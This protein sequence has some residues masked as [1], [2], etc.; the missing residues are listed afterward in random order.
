M[1]LSALRNYMKKFQVDD[2]SFAKQE[3]W[4]RKRRIAV[5]HVPQNLPSIFLIVIKV[6]LSR[7]NGDVNETTNRIQKGR[8]KKT[9]VAAYI[10]LIFEFPLILFCVPSGA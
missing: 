1:S 2:A 4:E 5:T 9:G 8:Q 7:T 6:L 10:F 3:N